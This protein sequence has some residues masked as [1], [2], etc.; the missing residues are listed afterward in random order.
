MAVLTDVQMAAALCEQ[1]YR[2]ADADQQLKYNEGFGNNI[3]T[4]AT[5]GQSVLASL[6]AKGFTY[7]NGF[8]YNNSTG[9]V[10]QIVEANAKIFVVFRGSDLSGGVGDAADAFFRGEAEGDP[11]VESDTADRYD[12]A[13]NR[14]LGL[15]SISQYQLADALALLEA[16]KTIAGEKDIVVTGQSLGGGL[17]GFNFGNCSLLPA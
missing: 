15:G 4:N 11:G 1:V 8:Y 17:A 14:E 2:R 10:G 12:W 16:A 13:C 9:F 6:E 3:P 7:N 5:I